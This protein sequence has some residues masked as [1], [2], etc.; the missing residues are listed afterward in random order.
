MQSQPSKRV[1]TKLV[2]EIIVSLFSYG[3]G[4]YSDMHTFEQYTYY[5]LFILHAEFNFK[6]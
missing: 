3:A 4:L 6:W 5:S 1:L 2:N